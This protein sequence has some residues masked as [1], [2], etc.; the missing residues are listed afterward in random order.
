MKSRT[1][2]YINVKSLRF[3]SLKKK[4][5]ICKITKEHKFRKYENFTS[6]FMYGIGFQGQVSRNRLLT[7]AIIFI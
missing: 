3:E 2:K 1:Q 4:T 5:K 7:S 6:R